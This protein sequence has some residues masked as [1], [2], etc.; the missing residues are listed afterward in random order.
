MLPRSTPS[1]A[2]PRHPNPCPANQLRT[3]ERS[4]ALFQNSS[5]SFSTTSP[6]FDKN[7]RGCTPPK[8]KPSAVSEPFSVP[9]LPTFRPSDLQTPFSARPSDAFSPPDLQT[10]RRFLRKTFQPSDFQTPFPRQTFR[11]SNAFSA[12][13]SDLQTP[14]S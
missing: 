4:C 14:F 9:D 13:P 7:P 11:P 6:L 5:P 1:P 3:L 10:F 2:T 8:P 12:R